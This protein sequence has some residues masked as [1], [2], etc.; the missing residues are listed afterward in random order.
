MFCDCP[1]ATNTLMMRAH[2]G[3]G[4]W[5]GR[6]AL[7]TCQAAT[8]ARSTSSRPCWTATAGARP[9]AAQPRSQMPARQWPADLQEL[10]GRGSGRLGPP[11]GCHPTLMAPVLAAHHPGQPQLGP[12]LVGLVQAGKVQSGV[13]LLLHPTSPSPA[14]HFQSPACTEDDCLHLIST[15]PCTTALLGSPGGSLSL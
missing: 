8:H 13:V 6:S 7:P 10:C 15:A 2:A 3:F 12:H 14:V 4:C 9:R 1:H 11:A 5:T